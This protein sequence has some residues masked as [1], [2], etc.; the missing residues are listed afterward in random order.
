MQ[1]AHF[2]SKYSIT[3]ASHCPREIKLSKGLCALGSED[4]YTEDHKK[5]THADIRRT[6]ESRS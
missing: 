4:V 5:Q 1:S 2:S 6:F 3:H